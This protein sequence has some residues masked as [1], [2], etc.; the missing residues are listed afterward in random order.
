L[1]LHVADISSPTLERQVTVVEG[2]LRELGLDR[3]PRVLALNKADRVDPAQAAILSARLGG[4]AVSAVRPETLL[5]LLEAVE[6][7]LWSLTQAVLP[8]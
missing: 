3:V 5:P 4:V 8:C 7:R 6:K 2:I 1:L